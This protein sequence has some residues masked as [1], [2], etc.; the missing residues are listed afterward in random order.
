MSSSFNF[1]RMRQQ[2]DRWG[3]ELFQE[4]VEFVDVK[5]RP[6]TVRSSDREVKTEN[7]SSRTYITYTIFFG[8]K[9]TTPLSFGLYSFFL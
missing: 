9:T 6:F 1:V 4:D 8:V 2:A 7:S 3:A 5:S